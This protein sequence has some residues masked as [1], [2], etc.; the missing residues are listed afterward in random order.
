[1]QE[2]WKKEE[3]KL[4][5]CDLERTFNA[6]D[7]NCQIYTD[8]AKTKKFNTIISKI[9]TEQHDEN[10]RLRFNIIHEKP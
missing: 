3:K 4:D 5:I 9:K 7:K 6:S 10:L 8:S 2:T 1:M